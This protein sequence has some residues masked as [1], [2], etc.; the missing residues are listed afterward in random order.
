MSCNQLF[1]F[2]EVYCLKGCL[3]DMVM[4]FRWKGG[5]QKWPP[6]MRLFGRWIF[7]EHTRHISTTVCFQTFFWWRL[8]NADMNFV[9]AVFGGFFLRFV[10][11]FCYPVIFGCQICA[12][13]QILS[14]SE[15]RIEA[16][17]SLVVGSWKTS[18]LAAKKKKRPSSLPV[19]PKL[20]WMVFFSGLGDL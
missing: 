10:W 19:I 6:A 18:T 1:R 5:V 15:F 3:V 12:T 13:K 9:R 8:C 20:R 17:K 7:N 14:E 11:S 2:W 4:I 16:F